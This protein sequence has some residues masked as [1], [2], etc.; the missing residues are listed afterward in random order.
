M[1]NNKFFTTTQSRKKQRTMNST[2]NNNNNNNDRVAI[3]VTLDDKHCI[4]CV[5]RG[6]LCSPV[7]HDFFSLETREECDMKKRNYKNDNKILIVN[8]EDKLPISKL[9]SAT[10][11]A[12]P[13]PTPA[14][15]QA[16]TQATTPST[17]P[18]TA[19]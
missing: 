6:G 8:V 19:S 5:K 16:T 12:P 17:V 9:H 2:N 4:T 7:R 10:A 18:R 3:G 15:T 14:I 11:T 1:Q 13:A